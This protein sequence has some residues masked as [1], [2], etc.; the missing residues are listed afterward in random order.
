MILFFYIKYIHLLRNF[1]SFEKAFAYVKPSG[2]IGDIDDMVSKL[3]I[4]EKG[5]SNLL[6]LL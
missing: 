2:E 4:R 1:S 6:S 5:I 3:F